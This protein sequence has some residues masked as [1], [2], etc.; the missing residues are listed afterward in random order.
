MADNVV[1]APCGCELRVIDEALVVDACGDGEGCP[2]VKYIIMETLLV[3][4]P[5]SVIEIPHS[6]EGV[7]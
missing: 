2:T 3:G 6:A 5:Y 1:T 4:N 7:S